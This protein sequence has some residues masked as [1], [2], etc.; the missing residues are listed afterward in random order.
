MNIQ[1]IFPPIKQ[2]AR[3]LAQTSARF[4]DEKASSNQ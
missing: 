4:L 3:I 2:K 1:R